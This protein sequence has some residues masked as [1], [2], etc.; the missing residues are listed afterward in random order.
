MTE[1]ELFSLVKKLIP[2]LK[3]TSTYSY[4]DGYSNDLKLTIEL[5]CRRRHY[6]Y[7]LIEKSK[8][9]KLLQ[10]KRMR[11]INSTPVGIFSFNL[12]KIEEPNWWVEE[13]PASTDFNRSQRINKEVGYLNINDAKNITNILQYQYK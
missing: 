7:L 1:R 3:E 5:K 8:Y 12:N 13:M 2:D 6:D 11:Y 10:N 9:E 4:R